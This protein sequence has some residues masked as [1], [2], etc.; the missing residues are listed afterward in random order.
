MKQ[1]EV[2]HF[3]EEDP[4]IPN[5][6]NEF[7]KYFQ[8]KFDEIPE[9]YKNSLKIEIRALDY[10]YC[11]SFSVKVSYMRPETEVEKKGGEDELI[12]QGLKQKENDLQELKRLNAL[13]PDLKVE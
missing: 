6:P 9:E 5:K 1:I 13:Y 10:Y 3:E 2:V 11:D 7:I 12:S 8:D 4:I